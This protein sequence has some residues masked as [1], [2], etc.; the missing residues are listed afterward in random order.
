MK[1]V[2]FNGCRDIRWKIAKNAI[3]YNFLN[4]NT[5]LKLVERFK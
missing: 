3:I 1:A 5:E 4:D 2:G